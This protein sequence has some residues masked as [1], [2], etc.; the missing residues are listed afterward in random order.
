MKILKADRIITGDGKTVLPDG[1]VAVEGSRIA[2]VHC[3]GVRIE[4]GRPVSCPLEASQVDLAAVLRLLRQTGREP[5]LLREEA[6]PARAAA[7]RA[8][9]QGLLA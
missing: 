4:G 6:V 9:L 2:A 3:K 1:A 5:P 7:D 8:F